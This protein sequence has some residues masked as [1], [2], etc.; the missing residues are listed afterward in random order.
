V[1][2]ESLNRL[3]TAFH[4]KHR[5]T[6]GHANPGEAVQM[7]NLRLS[8]TGKLPPIQL[9]QQFRQA[10]PGVRHRDAWFPA[11][12]RVACRAY[13][14]DGLA[15]RDTVVGPAV[16]DALDCTAVVPPGWSGTVDDQ[17]FIALRQTA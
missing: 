1:T 8:A 4:D 6:Y 10:D 12:G 13:W 16:I 5:Q 7:V 14:R 9:A 11:T 17:G 15:P 3:M 2:R